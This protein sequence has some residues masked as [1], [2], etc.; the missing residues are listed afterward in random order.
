M[1]GRTPLT[2]NSEK[3]VSWKNSD[4]PWVKA[5]RRRFRRWTYYLFLAVAGVI[6]YFV[7]ASRSAEILGWK[8]VAAIVL[9]C[10][11]LLLLVVSIVLLYRIAIERRLTRLIPSREGQICPRCRVALE[12]VEDEARCPVCAR[13]YSSSEVLE[14]WEKYALA[15]EQAQNPGD[16]PAA[17][18]RAFFTRNQSR[19]FRWALSALVITV[20]YPFYVHWGGL[21][22]ISGALQLLPWLIYGACFGYG[23]TL[24]QQ[25]RVRVGDSM[26]C[27]KCGYQKA[28]EGDDIAR[29]PECGAEWNKPGYT[30]KGKRVAR[31]GRLW[32]G[33]SMLAISFLILGGMFWSGRSRASW[34]QKCIPTSSLIHDVSQAQGFKTRMWAELRNRFLTDDQTK[35]LAEGLIDRRLREKYLS[36]DAGTWLWNTVQ[37]NALPDDL[38]KR[39]YQETLRV[40]IDG[41]PSTT[42]GSTIRVSLGSEYRRPNF[43]IGVHAKVYV[44]G[45]QID[46]AAQAL[47]RQEHAHYAS[48]LDE[49]QYAVFADLQPSKPGPLRIE[50]HLWLI[51]GARTPHEIKWNED[52]TP[53]IPTNTAWAE[54]IVVTHLVDVHE[55]EADE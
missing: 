44:A 2:N 46:N 12:V 14:Y 25:Y 48:L 1:A 6:A 47:S 15:P 9:L 13:V 17:A 10:F 20:V 37:S 32:A 40:W 28:P 22:W 30:V 19:Y 27:A 5:M 23:T 35:Q 53:E 36:N 16:A 21:S 38:V 31:H 8:S 41:P 29:C 7:L 3:T 43:P 45:F 39:Y 33:I 4:S 18:F 34:T 52:G 49:P 24:I 55:R 51:V 26:H 54:E 11:N 42:A 50:L